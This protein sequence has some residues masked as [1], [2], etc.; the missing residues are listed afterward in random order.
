M[1]DS[2]YRLSVKGPRTK[3]IVKRRSADHRPTERSQNLSQEL[4]VFTS[5][6][7]T[8]NESVRTSLCLE[9]MYGKAFGRTSLGTQNAAGSSL[10]GRTESGSP[11]FL[12][13]PTHSSLQDFDVFSLDCEYNAECLYRIDHAERLFP[14]ASNSLI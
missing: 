13:S 2:S 4:L 1:G 3:S 7:H 12:P 9:W 6:V 10:P 5:I 8:E 14:L 11:N